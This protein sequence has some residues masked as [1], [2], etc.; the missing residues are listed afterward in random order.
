[1]TDIHNHTDLMYWFFIQHY[2]MFRLTGSVM[3]LLTFVS[4]TLLVVKIFN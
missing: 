4:T 2:Y 3:V 1:M